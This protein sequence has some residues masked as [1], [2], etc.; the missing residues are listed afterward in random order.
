MFSLANSTLVSLPVGNSIYT[1]P[2]LGYLR[3]QIQE[4]FDK[5]QTHFR[6]RFS[7]HYSF[8]VHLRE[9]ER[10]QGEIPQQR[11]NPEEKKIIIRRK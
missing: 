2:Q 10:K 5:P 1:N 8:L 4:V 6:F 9:G 11:N 3:L 7:T